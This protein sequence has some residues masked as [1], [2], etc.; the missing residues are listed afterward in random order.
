MSRRRWW[1]RSQNRGS[2]CAVSAGTPRERG[3]TTPPQPLPPMSNP[4]DPFLEAVRLAAGSDLHLTSGSLPR[5]RIDGRLLPLRRDEENHVR[6]LT[7]EDVRALVLAAMPPHL[8]AR[9]EAERE[10]DFSYAG[11]ATGRFRVNACFSL[12]GPAA[13]FRRVPAPPASMEEVGLPTSVRGVPDLPNGL[14]LLV[15]PTGAGKS[16]TMA[17]L[18]SEVNERRAGKI[19][20]LEDPIEF[21]YEERGC[22]I[23]QREVGSHTRS[24]AAAAR[25]GLRQDPD[26][27]AIGEVRQASVL[28]QVL[29][30]AETG[31]LVFTTVHAQSAAGGIA[32]VLGLMEPAREEAVRR[33]LAGTIRA[34]IAQ[35]LV[36]RA[37]RG[38]RIAAYEVLLRTPSTVTKIREGNLAS[39]RSDLSDRGAGMCT[40]ERSLAELVIRGEVREEDALAMANAPEAVLAELRSALGGTAS[41]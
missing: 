29:A 26:V 22:V 34:V 12:R 25:A 5:V 1:D 24:Y 10:V 31:H 7:S 41:R 37:D 3:R 32:R 11:T 6:E 40:L 19:L 35:T 15:G 38:G 21:A 20:T 28:R 27:I 16:T 23:S 13:V 30:L 36:P 4:I 39:L 8:H 2:G 18:V 17:A 14:V 33:Q 9:W